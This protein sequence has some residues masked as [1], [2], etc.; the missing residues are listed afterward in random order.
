[1]A[2]V[3]RGQV[4]LPGGRTK[5]CGSFLLDLQPV[6]NADFLRYV[7]ERGAVA[8]A[9]MHKRGFSDPDQPVVGVTLAEARAYARW[10]G[11]RLPTEAEW[12]RAARGDSTRPFPWGDAPPHPAHACFGL[13]AT[14]APDPVSET[15]PH[16]QGPFGHQNL[17]GNVW[18]WCHEGV[19]KGGFWGAERV[20]LDDRLEER[21]DRRSAG[22]GF[23]CAR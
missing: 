4:V 5:R 12:L 23:R 17:S 1:M 16:G 19:L 8:P 10:A 21:G 7:Q 18:E 2:L 22:I 14:G 15:R 9:W 6:T 20:T 3:P 13:G 11:K